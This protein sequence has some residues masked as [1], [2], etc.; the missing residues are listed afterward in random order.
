MFVLLLAEEIHHCPCKNHSRSFGVI[1]TRF[2]WA[3]MRTAQVG[4]C[5]LSIQCFPEGCKTPKDTCETTMA[6]KICAANQNSGHNA[7]SWWNG[8]E[9]HKH[10][11]L[12]LFLWDRV[13]MLLTVTW[14]LCYLP[15]ICWSILHLT[16]MFPG[17]EK[18]EFH[19]ADAL[20]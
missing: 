6:F 3:K 19:S 8:A 17:L 18:C 15:F 5:F 7:N 10:F 2:L 11:L 20:K 13:V 16:S 4:M 14:P 12:H 1:Y 9:V